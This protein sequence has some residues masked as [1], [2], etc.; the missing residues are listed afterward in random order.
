MT[1]ADAKD[2][3]ERAVLLIPLDVI[4]AALKHYNAYRTGIS[5]LAYFRSELAI[6][7]RRAIDG[8]TELAQ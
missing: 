4:E 1:N 5:A 3:A 2:L 8:Q 6:A 7:A